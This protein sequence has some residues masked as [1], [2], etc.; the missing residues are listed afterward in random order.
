MFASIFVLVALFVSSASAQDT[1]Y[2]TATECAESFTGDKLAA[3]TLNALLE[4]SEAQR[5]LAEERA[6]EASAEAERVRE[7]QAAQERKM[8]ELE[9][10]HEATLRRAEEV[11][12]STPTP[13]SDL[14]PAAATAPAMRIVRRGTE[15]AALT[16]RQISGLASQ[17]CLVNTAYAV[18]RHVRSKGIDLSSVRI[19]AMKDGIPLQPDLGMT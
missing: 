3:C 5:K 8:A 2:L 9:R 7:A 1:E 17:L 15:Y 11:A 14:D 16:H 10:D 12:R 18:G 19:V 13:P 6:A 4:E